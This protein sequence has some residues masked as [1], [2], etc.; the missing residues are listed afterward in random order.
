M[1]RALSA[2]GNNASGFAWFPEIDRNLPEYQLTR[3]I[4]VAAAHRVRGAPRKCHR[5][6]SAALDHGRQSG[7]L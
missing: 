7:V 6:I 5:N 2:G 1:T 4:C 3:V